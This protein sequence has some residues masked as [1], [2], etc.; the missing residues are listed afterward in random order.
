M[1]LG[2]AAGV[3]LVHGIAGAIAGSGS[4]V[5]ARLRRPAAR[6]FQSTDGSPQ[7]VLRDHRLSRIAA[8]N[9]LLK[10]NPLAEAIGLEL[11]QARITLNVGEYLLLRSLCALS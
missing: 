7:E 5:R 11:Q 10:A 4:A 6:E 3:C 8:L 2:F 1:F 9:L